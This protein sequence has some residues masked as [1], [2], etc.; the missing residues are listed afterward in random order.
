MRLYGSESPTGTLTMSPGKSGTSQTRRHAEGSLDKSCRKLGAIGIWHTQ[1]IFGPRVVS[2]APD[3]ASPQHKVVGC[4]R[5]QAF[6]LCPLSSSTLSPCSTL[7]AVTISWGVGPIFKF[8]GS[9]RWS[10][11]YLLNP[12]LRW[13]VRAL[14]LIIFSGTCR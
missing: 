10:Q 6:L 3:P 13:K 2:K 4:D 7:A 12:P 1:F 11:R 9:T 5:A 8:R 14:H